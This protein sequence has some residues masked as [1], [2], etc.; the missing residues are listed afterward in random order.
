MILHLRLVKRAA[1]SHAYPSQQANLTNRIDIKAMEMQ[2]IA[3]KRNIRKY[4]P[5]TSRP[6]RAQGTAWAWM[7]V[8]D[9][10]SSLRISAIIMSSKPKWTNDTHGLG[11]SPPVACRPSFLRSA[12]TCGLEISL[13]KK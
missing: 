6:A 12:E 2:I 13:K 10:Y 11:T 8:G 4:I 9:V 3:H 7:G 5:I 1:V